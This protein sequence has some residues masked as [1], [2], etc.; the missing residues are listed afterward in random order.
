MDVVIKQSKMSIKRKIEEIEL[1]INGYK[2]FKDTIT[3]STGE[4]QVTQGVTLSTSVDRLDEIKKVNR[5]YLADDKVLSDYYN[6]GSWIRSMAVS[7]DIFDK[8]VENPDKYKLVVLKGS[9]LLYLNGKYVPKIVSFGRFSG[10][11]TNAM[12]DIDKL[13]AHLEK[14]PGKFI[15]IKDTRQDMYSSI[16][17]LKFNWL[18][19]EVEY[20]ALI[21][22]IE[23][24]SMDGVK[25]YLGI[26][27]FRL[28]REHNCN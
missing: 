1:N 13:K 12:Y 8:Y 26:E 25:Q 14:S 20:N 3:F 9:S 17:E 22:S 28:N 5:V 19:D 15:D 4:T 10:L 6:G 16:R 23:S 27:W 11:I 24:V 2:L 21:K 7:E 18:P